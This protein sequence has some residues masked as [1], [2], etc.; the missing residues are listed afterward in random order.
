MN[1]VLGNVDQFP[2]LAAI[3][4]AILSKVRYFTLPDGTRVQTKV[5]ANGDV[6]GV[7]HA[8]RRYV[9]Q[10]R[11]KNSPEGKRAR[12]GATIIW[13][14]QTHNDQTRQPLN[15]NKWVGKIEDGIVRMR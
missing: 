12:E 6:M 2:Q 9:A 10:N 3:V 8:C 13:V 7:D 1:N 4:G 5:M 11:N 15:P 14:I